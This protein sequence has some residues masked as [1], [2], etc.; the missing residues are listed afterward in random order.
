MTTGTPSFRNRN[1]VD[2]AN[3]FRPSL[4]AVT[5]HTGFVIRFYFER[6][7]RL[8]GIVAGGARQRLVLVTGAFGK[9]LRVAGDA[10]S[11]R[12]L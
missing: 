1:R 2:G 12:I 4:A 6:L 7:G 11:V 3:G 9:P 5:R 10:K 8:M